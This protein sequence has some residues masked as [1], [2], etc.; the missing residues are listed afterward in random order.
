M[1]TAAA[2]AALSANWDQQR[3]AEEEACRHRLYDLVHSL[4]ED[5]KRS[6][7]IHRHVLPAAGGASGVA[8]SVVAFVKEQGAEL[9]VVGSRGMGAARSTLMSLIGL[10]SVSSYLV[11]NLHCPVAVYRGRADDTAA[12]A[13]RR[14]LVSLDDSEASRQ[15]LEWAVGNVLGPTDELHLVCVALPIPFPVSP[16]EPYTSPPLALDEWQASYGGSL[17]HTEATLRAAEEHTGSALKIVAEDAAAS[18][19]LEADEYD[20]ATHDSN[21]YARETV[22]AAVDRA[23][24]KVERERIFFKALPPEGG[25]SDVG[26]SV[27][28]YSKA[29]GVDLVVLGA[30]GMGSFKRAMLSFVGLGSVSD[31]VVSH[32]EVPVIV[33]K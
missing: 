31:Y 28:H 2:V 9:V 11:H 16:A 23:V 25:A 32:V 29:N 15:A 20:A 22:T 24:A 8:E 12:K 21:H 14:V 26:Q 17:Q 3:K 4:P 13:K 27:V 19:V 1:A 18:E 10:G 33:V 30:R 5:V 7:D 6:V